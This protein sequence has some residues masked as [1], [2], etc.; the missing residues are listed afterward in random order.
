M[1]RQ[2]IEI[3]DSLEGVSAAQWDAL[4]GPEPLVSHA[5]LGALE[6]TGCAVELDEAGYRIT[7]LSKALATLAK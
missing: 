1:N 6:K 4:A 5:F 3:V 7:K 2:K